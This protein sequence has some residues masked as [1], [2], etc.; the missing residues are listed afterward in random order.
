MEPTLR[1]GDSVLV[2]QSQRDVVYGKIYV[3]GIDDGV[4]VKRL[5]KR[6]GKLVLLSDNRGDYPPYEIQLNDAVDVRV[7]G[8]VIWMAREIF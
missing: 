5:D 2:D 3:V 7:I 6:P 1:D 4:V 8:R